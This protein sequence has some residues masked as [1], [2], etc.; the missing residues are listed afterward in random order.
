M[1]ARH[2]VIATLIG[3]ILLLV[4]CMILKSS[5]AEFILWKID[6]ISGYER[7]FPAEHIDGY[8]ITLIQKAGIDFYDT[9]FQ[10]NTPEGKVSRFLV[11]GDDRRWS[12]PRTIIEKDR[13]YYIDGPGQITE[14][15]SY[16]DIRNK[17]VYA[18]YLKRTLLL[19]SLN[20]A[21][22]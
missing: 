21:K 7:M 20:S 4:A 13:I 17:I 19:A 2:F 10:I 16:I 11:D 6:S 22:E 12:N 3:G 1:K 18:G 14:Q 15:T 5:S 8:T 9:Y